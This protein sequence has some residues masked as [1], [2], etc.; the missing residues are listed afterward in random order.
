MVFYV[1]AGHFLLT[2]LL[3]EDLKKSGADGGDARVVV[4]TSSVHDPETMKRRGR[5]YLTI[6]Q[7]CHSQLKHTKFHLSTLFVHA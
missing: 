4:V 3:L 2:N 7:L 6:S 5:K 1:F